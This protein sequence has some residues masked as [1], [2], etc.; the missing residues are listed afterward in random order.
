LEVGTKVES[1]PV[2]TCVLVLGAFWLPREEMSR[3][4]LGGLVPAGFL[5]VCN[6]ELEVE[7][8]DDEQSRLRKRLLIG[9]R[10]A[11]YLSAS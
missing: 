10:E 9:C 5:N 4:W 11:F 2:P 8:L 6:R 3:C 1:D 7:A